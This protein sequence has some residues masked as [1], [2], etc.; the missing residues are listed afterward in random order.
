MKLFM[1]SA[2]KSTNSN[3]FI[4]KQPQIPFGSGVTRH[5]LKKIRK[6]VKIILDFSL[7]LS[8]IISSEKTSGC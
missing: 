6:K 3:S 4:S 1:S 7:S 8:Y 2:I 5:I